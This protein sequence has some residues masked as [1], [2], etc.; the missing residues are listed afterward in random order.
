MLLCNNLLCFVFVLF[1][2]LSHECMH[3]II[4]GGARFYLVSSAPSF[5]PFVRF[6]ASG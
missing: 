3:A 1:F 6:G 4:Y 5:A 2:N